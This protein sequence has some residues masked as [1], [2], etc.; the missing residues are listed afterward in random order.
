[1]DPH[2][3]EGDGDDDARPAGRSGSPQ[4]GAGRVQEDEVSAA[5]DVKQ[6]VADAVDRLAGDLEALSHR[7]HDNPE[8]C[9]KEE[10]AH[11]RPT[12]F[13]DKHGAR[14]ERGI[15]GLPTAFRATIEGA[16]AGPTIAI[17]AE[18]DALPS[19]GHAC[20]HNVIATAGTG[21]GA[22]LAVALG[23]LPFA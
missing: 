22:A 15:G 11:A 4:A 16:G 17:M 7:I 8:L 2:R 1:R 18:Y 21:A 19:I 23:T 6:K 20:G 13:L 10:K 3:G 12:E 9:F 14:V 5:G